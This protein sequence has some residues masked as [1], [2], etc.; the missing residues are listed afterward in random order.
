MSVVLYQNN[1]AVIQ[2]VP[3]GTSRP[4]PGI[5][6]MEIAIMWASDGKHVFVQSQTAT[7]INIYKVDIESGKRELWQA[8]TPKDA[9]GLR[10][11]TIPVSVTP[12]GRWIAYAWRT[13]LGQLY[14][15]DTLK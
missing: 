14:S 1:K 15:S 13:Q 2:S 8:I 12:D 7:G 4:L 3:G 9:A 5:Q 11:M 6:P 10:P